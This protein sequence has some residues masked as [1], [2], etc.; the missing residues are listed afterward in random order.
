MNKITHDLLDAIMN[1]QLHLYK[2]RINL[3]SGIS[4]EIDCCKNF[5][6]YDPETLEL[7]IHKD[8]EEEREYLD[9]PIFSIKEKDIEAWE[10][11]T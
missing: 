7:E 1:E 8:T 9:N 6:V 5:F 11:W 10:E 2:I 4:I 3:V